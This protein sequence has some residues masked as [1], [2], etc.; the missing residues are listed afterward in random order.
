MA[1]DQWFY[2]RG[3]DIN[4]PVS[5]VELAA[6]ANS[7]TVIASDTVWKDGN[8]T[9]VPA[10][11]VK[12]LFSAENM[13]PIARAAPAPAAV[14]SGVE[15]YNPAPVE[16][17]APGDAARLQMP[18]EGDELVPVDGVAAP[19]ENA[20][21]PPKAPARKARAVA[22]KGAV[23]MGQDGVNVK[24]KLKCTKCGHEDS[25][26]KTAAITRGSVRST[27]FCPKCKKKCDGEVHFFQ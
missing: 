14:P 26:W 16:V 4:G 6:L 9:G 7:G 27:Y 3:A 11:Q 23:I 13:A 17:A 19:A 1:A 24:Y 5:G 18:L 15:I 12:H 21:P 20:P 25:S 22:G 8:E 2:G 10:R